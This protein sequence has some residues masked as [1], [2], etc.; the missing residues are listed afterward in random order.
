MALYQLS[1]ALTFEYIL[2]SSFYSDEAPLMNFFSCP[3][4][5]Q[6]LLGS[7]PSVVVHTSGPSAL[8]AKS[9]GAQV[10]WLPE[11]FTS[12]FPAR[13]SHDTLIF[14]C[15]RLAWHLSCRPGLGICS[16]CVSLPSMGITGMH[17]HVASVIIFS[18]YQNAQ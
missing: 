5:T 16:S 9:G 3:S 15:F 10:P 17:P 4:D 8:E 13:P 14:L 2:A 7:K 6:C 1:P 18:K 11:L 12:A